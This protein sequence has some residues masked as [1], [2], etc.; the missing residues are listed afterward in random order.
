M[1]FLETMDPLD[2]WVHEVFLG[3]EDDLDLLDLQGLVVMMELLEHLAKWAL[4]VHL[5]LQD[6]PVLLV[7]REKLGLQAL[8]VQM[9]LLE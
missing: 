3:K 6:F 7:L 8:L 2:Q 9:A 4:L 1:V 5:D